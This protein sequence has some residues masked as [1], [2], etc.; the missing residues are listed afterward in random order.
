MAPRIS[1]GAV[2]NGAIAYQ[3]D[4]DPTQFHYFPSSPGLTLDDNLK[5]YS[6]QYWGIG[7]RYFAEDGS[8]GQ[9]NSLVGATVSGVTTFDLTGP[10]KE[11]LRTAISQT[12][13]IEKPKVKLLPMRLLN[14]QVDPVFAKKTLGVA[15]DGEFTFPSIVQVGSSVA[16]NVA[17]GAGKF[18]QL[19]ANSVAAG[20]GPGVAS[21]NFALNIYADVELVADPWVVEITAKL[22][23]VWEYTRMAF[24]AKAQIGWFNLD[25]SLEKIMQD[26]QK[27][28]IV[29]IKYIEGTYD[30][31]SPGLQLFEQGK[32]IFDELNKQ[33]SAGE[34]L[35]K[36]EPNP[37]PPAPPEGGGP[38]QPWSIQLNASYQSSFFQQKIEKQIRLEY[39]GRTLRSTV[40]GIALAVSC[41]PATKQFFYDLGDPDEPC[42]TKAKVD[43]MQARLEAEQKA[44]NVVVTSA[45]KDLDKGTINPDEYSIVMRYLQQNSLT[46][47]PSKR[48][49]TLFFAP[50]ARRVEVYSFEYAKRDYQHVLSQIRTGR[51]L[52]K[53]A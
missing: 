29:T 4:G 37:A 3:D 44:Q 45:S 48:A 24:E 14:V 42:I 9:I 10:Q 47:S 2:S 16:F 17:N 36:I 34:G 32:A 8:N 15:S 38:V 6:A 46:E 33:I 25:T 18:A 1:K 11:E 40:A 12:Y 53:T 31:N 21:P 49:Q 39:A 22:D 51:I 26:L 23:Q 50:G 28:E 30:K 19:F 7:R 52:E 13:D 20:G 43:L 35:F 27:K 41:G 5:A